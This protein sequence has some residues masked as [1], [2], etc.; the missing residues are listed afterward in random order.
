MKKAW[1]IV[2]FSVSALVVAF[3]LFV[4]VF[5]FMLYRAQFPDIH[6][7]SQA[8][9]IY[10]QKSKDVA[11]MVRTWF[12]VTLPENARDVYYC[13]HGAFFADKYAAFRLDSEEQCRAFFENQGYD[14][15]KF[16][17]GNFSP[18]GPLR[19]FYPPHNWEDKYQDSNWRLSKDDDF[20][21]HRCHDNHIDY[22]VYTPQ[23][24]RIYLFSGGGP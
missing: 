12:G 10:I 15:D 1:K 24:N 14:L 22:I 3:I 13:T 16:K 21:Y 11:A 8:R 19:Y 20:L 2:L 18:D 23:E 17:K 4:A 7:D 6:S 5:L 9:E